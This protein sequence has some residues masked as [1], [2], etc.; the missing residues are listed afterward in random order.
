MAI[1]IA[2]IFFHRALVFTAWV[3]ID[4]KPLSTM[5]DWL[6]TIW[7][8]QFSGMLCFPLLKQ[9]TSTSNKLPYHLP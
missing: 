7:T 5:V 2:H 8:G 6:Q 9:R 3:S 4:H 1:L